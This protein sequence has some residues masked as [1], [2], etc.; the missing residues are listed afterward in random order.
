MMA[1]KKNKKKRKTDS[2]L[3]M[4][5]SKGKRNIKMS[6]RGQEVLPAGVLPKQAI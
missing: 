6:F 3:P 2:L 5:S 1:K 4:K